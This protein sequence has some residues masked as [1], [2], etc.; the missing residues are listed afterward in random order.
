MQEEIAHEPQPQNPRAP[1]VTVQISTRNRGELLAR[2]LTSLFAVEFPFADLE[3][4]V[5]DDGSTDET[6]ALV[7]ALSP[8][9]AFQYIRQ[10]HAGLAAA[11][12]A[13][14]RAAR[15]DVVLL[16][17]DDVIATPSLVAAHWEGH[18]RSSVPAIVVGR[19]RH[20]STPEIPTRVRPRLADLSTS[21]FWTCNASVRR[22]DLVAGGLF[23][24]RFREYGW[25]DLEFGERLRRRGLKRY[26]SGGAL[27]YH[28]K[29]PW[30]G[31]D[32]PRL[33]AQA[34]ASGRS[35]VVYLR[36]RSTWRARL[37]TGLFP[38]R[39]HVNLW[40]ARYEPL[41]WRLTQRAGNG[42]LHGVARAAAWLLLRARYYRSA[43]EAQ[44]V[45]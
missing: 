45:S 39:V 24:E 20:I 3:I 31:S 4:V 29:P 10:P 17:D 18:Q 12:N 44:G 21:F 34:E 42:T 16:L 43:M 30:R 5:V 26:R 35:A 9:C 14:I 8:P 13:G 6:P 19:V 23:D 40:A 25:E 27:V 37:A 22:A 32:L 1:R 2:C 15:G 38:P 36:K 33:V 11:R 7:A 41:W 28:V